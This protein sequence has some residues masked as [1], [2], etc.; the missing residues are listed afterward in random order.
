EDFSGVVDALLR[1][2]HLEQGPEQAQAALDLSDAADKCGRQEEARGALELAVQGS[3]EDARLRMRLRQVYEALDAYS[4]LAALT[5][6]DAEHAPDDQTRF[7]L[8][9]S[10]GD[11]YLRSVGE[12]ANAIDPLERALQLKPFHHE[13]TLLLA[14]AY[15]VSGDID[16]A[17]ALLTPAIERHKGKRS[18]EVAALQHRMARA[19]NAGGG[20]D[21]E[22]QW[23]TKALEC[24]MQNG[25][26]AAELAEVAIELRQF[27]VALKALKAVTLLR[28]PGPMSRALATLRQGQ[29]A[30]QQGDSKRAVI[31][32]KQALRD[33]PGMAEAEEFLRELGA[34]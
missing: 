20:R 17:V 26:V 11:L 10:V 19:A 5:M 30:Y 2:V 22:L 12:E 15:T 24:D 25:Q 34:A 3:P 9:I 6:L 29:I 33:E 13:T 23:L 27:D 18:K 7:D 28:T 31:L 16:R 8:L 21:V 14:D 4:E 1:I 32:A